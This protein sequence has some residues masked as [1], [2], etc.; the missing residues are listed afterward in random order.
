MTAVNP[1]DKAKFHYG[2][3]FEAGSKLVA[4]V[5]DQKLFSVLFLR[6]NSK[7]SIVSNVS[8]MSLV[9]FAI[10]LTCRNVM[11]FKSK[12]IKMPYFPRSHLN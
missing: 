5:C 9:S 4:P 12:N 8:K 3:W 1:A 11:S 6:H 10:T 7:L 2:S